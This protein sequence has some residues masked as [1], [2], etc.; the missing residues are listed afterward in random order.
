MTAFPFGRALLH[1]AKWRSP[2]YARTTWSTVM[3]ILIISSVTALS[4]PF[5]GKG[6]MRLVT[7][8]GFYLSLAILWNLLAG[9]G[10]LLSVG[11]QAYVG[12]GAY[13]FYAALVFG[14]WPLTVAFL[15]AAV[16]G[17]IAAGF[18]SLFLFRLRGPYFAVGTW[19]VAEVALLTFAAWELFGGGAG[20][21][22]PV[23]I[24]REIGRTPVA[25]ELTLFWAMLFTLFFVLTGSYLLL[26]SRFG[27]AMTAIRDSQKAA[28]SLGINTLR[29]KLGLFVSVAAVTALLGGIIVLSKLR[30]TPD[31]AFSLIDWTAY[32]LFIV[33]IGG[34]GRFEGPI[35]GTIVFFVLRI[36][37]AD[38]GVFYLMLLGAIAIAVM[39]REP[40][41]LWG[42]ISRRFKR[43]LFPLNRPFKPDTTRESQ[44]GK[45]EM[46]SDGDILSP[47]MAGALFDGTI[48]PASGKPVPVTDKA[49]G[50]ELF[51]G[52]SAT[53]DDV[54]EVCRT[55]ASA[56]V[57]WAAMSPIARGDVL[58]KFAQLCEEHAEEVG[59]WIIRETGSIPPKAPFEVM[60]SARE[61]IETASLT[62]Q[63]VGYIL[64]SEQV[65]A[66]YARRVP[67]GVVAVITPWNSPFILATRILLPALAMGNACVLK[68]D[69]Q[70]P[71]CGGY[72]VA[73]LF[74]LAG[75]PRG[76]ISVLPGGGDVGAALVENPDINMIAFTGSTATGRK[77]G[78]AAGRHLK[79][80]ALELG[81]N[82]ATIV[83]ADADIDGA[84]NA[85]AFGSFFHQGQICFTIGRHL[86]HESVAEEYSR[87]LAEK[88]KSLHIGNPA[89]D[90]CH[91]G[92]II[93]E[94]QAARAE[95]LMQASI[96]MGAKVL[97]GGNRDKLNF[98]PTVLS[99]V[100]PQMPV[101]AQETFGPVAPIVTFKSEAE[102][103]EL[104][105]GVDYGL[106]TSLFTSNQAKAMELSKKLKTG[107]VH[108][109]DQTV[110][111]EVFGPIGGMGA[112]GNGARSGGPS[113]M[114]E[115]SQW[116]WITVND[117][118]PEYPF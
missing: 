27:L 69:Q 86:V 44:M 64:A 114:D 63:P 94:K 95:G 42:L 75:V 23:K 57:E 58:R 54:A 78:E 53:S 22:V 6:S 43:D 102:A 77:V 29:I 113:V 5:L 38:F 37:F 71:V 14:H 13:S 41:G 115:Y 105:N 26:R 68:P 36:L 90:Q 35:I 60:T 99:G 8:F 92:P 62:G 9:Y 82:N 103:L 45:Y 49:T 7:E 97:A 83:L 73:K 107:I 21:S 15:T 61:A 18:F 67:L 25:R 24:A 109:N 110:L 55:A 88:A 89:V 20:I 80:T 74:E 98:A 19:V 46:I 66:S 106:A 10:G 4:V 31:S 65:R 116:Q 72:L 17:G 85:A 91:L 11:Q 28:E 56:Q 101:Y 1:A 40:D 51:L 48:R 59:K 111:H 32:V 108:I 12:I 81:G 16:A 104:A 100:T 96:D 33:V 50:E 76:V 112:S 87:K 84:V 39:L 34:I 93:N 2:S 47:E 70:T 3:V 52:G 118:I 30:I 79:K 117:A